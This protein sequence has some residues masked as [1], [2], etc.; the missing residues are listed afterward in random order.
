MAAPSVVP[1][2]ASARAS[3][4]QAWTLL[5]VPLAAVPAQRVT[6]T[7]AGQRCVVTVYQK[8]TYRYEPVMTQVDLTDANAVF[9]LGADGEQL[10]GPPILGGVELA[11]GS[12]L[13]MDLAVN[14]R[15]VVQG[16]LCLHNQLVVRDPYL[17][18]VGDFVFIDMQGAA[19]PHPAGLGTRWHLTYQQAVP[20]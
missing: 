9:L 11:V 1:G 19:P 13:Y 15:A 8:P 10:L 16:A 5:V 14:G 6:V 12:A 3:V 7:L 18:F 2:G 17:G 4:A 20:A